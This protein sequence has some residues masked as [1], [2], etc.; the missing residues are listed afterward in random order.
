MNNLYY[1]S[2]ICFR[3]VH[4]KPYLIR[5]TYVEFYRS[6]LVK[7][8]ILLNK[9]ILGA[10][11]FKNTEQ[12]LNF[13]AEC[14]ANVLVHLIFCFKNIN[15]RCCQMTMHERA[16]WLFL[17]GN[18]SLESSIP[19]ELTLKIVLEHW[20][21]W[22]LTCVGGFF[23]PSPFVVC[24]SCNAFL[25]ISWQYIIRQLVRMKQDLLCIYKWK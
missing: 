14:S 21:N 22:S 11:Y 12:A 25:W 13:A 8:F 9:P 1:F 5:F 2:P 3:H 19:K 20:I 10:L 4:P 6:N 23:F 7:I 17:E 18:D 16:V 24:K 15:L